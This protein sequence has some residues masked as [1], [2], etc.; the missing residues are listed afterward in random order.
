MSTV[1]CRSGSGSDGVMAW[2]LSF[3]V[4][5]V[6]VNDGAAVIAAAMVQILVE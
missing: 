5:V 4:V 6:D 2:V 1:S 3:L